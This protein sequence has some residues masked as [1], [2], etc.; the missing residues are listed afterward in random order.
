MQILLR[1]FVDFI[2]K[3]VCVGGDGSDTGTEA[4]IGLAAGI[5]VTPSWIA[6]TMLC[7][8]ATAEPAATSTCIVV[9]PTKRAIALLSKWKWISSN[10]LAKR[11]AVAR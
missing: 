4:E 2:I 3:T 5:G 1:Y 6:L 7:S 10:A 11:R 8:S 9:S